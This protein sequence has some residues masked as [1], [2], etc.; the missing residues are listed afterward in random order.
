MAEGTRL[1]SEYGAK[2]PS[3]V[4]I[5][6]SPLL[7]TPAFAGRWPRIGRSARYCRASVRCRPEAFWKRKA[8]GA[9]LP[10]VPP[11][12]RSGDD[13]LQVVRHRP[14]AKVDHASAKRLRVDQLKVDR[15]VEGREVG[16][17]AAE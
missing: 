5:P 7:R 15:F 8:P 17:A 3:R 9:C 1:L 16:R 14:V 12:S 6:P 13:R 11:W 4:R 10:A 2:S